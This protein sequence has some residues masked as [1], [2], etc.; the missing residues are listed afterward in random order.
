MLWVTT[1]IV[2]PVRSQRLSSSALNRS[3]VSA[4]RALNGS[5]RSSTLGSRARARAIE[6]R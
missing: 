3:R 6:I 1:T 2:V 5:S 4:S